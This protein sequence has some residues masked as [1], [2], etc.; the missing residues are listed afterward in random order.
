MGTDFVRLHYLTTE[1]QTQDKASGTISTGMGVP[2]LIENETLE[3]EL[4]N[5]GFKEGEKPVAPSK[6][7]SS[8]SLT[9]GARGGT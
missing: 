3:S 2:T 8:N 6:R 4:A 9:C 7:G 1:I 5:L